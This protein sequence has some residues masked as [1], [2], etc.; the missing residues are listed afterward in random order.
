[1]IS[2]TRIQTAYTSIQ[3]TATPTMIFSSTDSTSSLPP[4]GTTT[5]DHILPPP[6]LSPHNPNSPAFIDGITGHTITRQS[7][8]RDSLRLSHALCSQSF[9]R[10]DKTKREPVI[11]IFSPNSMDYP[12]LFLGAQAAGCITSLVNASYMTDELAHQI[13]DSTPFIIFIHPTL[14]DVLE[15]ALKLLRAEGYDVEGVEIYSASAQG[16]NS[17][18]SGKRYSSYQT[19]FVEDGVVDDEGSAPA[20][21][22]LNLSKEEIDNTP[23]LLCYSSGT[24]SF[25][26]VQS[27]L[28]IPTS[29]S[30]PIAQHLT[31]VIHPVKPAKR[32]RANPTTSTSHRPAVQKASSRPTRTSPTSPPDGVHI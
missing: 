17:E 2:F 4:P 8:R 6:S 11:M 10:H 32:A 27:Q 18:K 7:L 21:K 25:E 29:T 3:H 1:M 23:A 22:G 12:I 28:P 16:I 15:L 20:Y 14:V 13:R 5:F 24:V 30:T 26:R 9:S 31:S 19:L